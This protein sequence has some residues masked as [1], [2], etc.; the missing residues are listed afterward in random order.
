M[1]KALLN[2]AQNSDGTM[3]FT[4]RS[5]ADNP[6]PE[7]KPGNVLFKET[8]DKCAGKGGNPNGDTPA[9]WSGSAG[10][11]AFKPDNEGWN[12][13]RAYGA[14]KCARFGSS[15][16]EGYATTPSF[17]A[18]GTVNLTCK[19]GA[20]ANTNETLT[21]SYGDNEIKSLKVPGGQWIDINVNFEGNGEN[22][23][24]FAGIQRMFLDEIEVKA[25]ATGIDNI[26][27]STKKANGRIY[28]IDGRYVG[29]NKAL[30]PSGMYIVDG[31]KFVK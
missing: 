2:I 5:A 18:T 26:T 29:T 28:T 22:T 14:Y 21:I 4:F 8:F 9:I 27:T 11:A 30:L 12:Y 16:A 13:Y 25:V 1:N 10:S 19:V 6:V 15:Q 7:V 20:W 3:S 17:Y 23:I 24:S 31:K